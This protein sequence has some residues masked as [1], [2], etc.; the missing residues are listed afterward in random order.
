[1]IQKQIEEDG[2]IVAPTNVTAGVEGPKLP[3][4]KDKNLFKRVQVLKKK[5]PERVAHGFI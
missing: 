1:M 4:N 5:T 3:I 2:A